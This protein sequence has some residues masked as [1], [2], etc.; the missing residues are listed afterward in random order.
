MTCSY[1]LK[2]P[3]ISQRKFNLFNK[4]WSNKYQNSRT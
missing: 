4:Q 2:N 3:W 1:I